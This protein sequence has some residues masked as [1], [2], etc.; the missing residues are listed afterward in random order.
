M[1]VWQYIL[2][3]QKALKMLNVLAF[4]ASSAFIGETTTVNITKENCLSMDVVNKLK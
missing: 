1:R 3:N 2:G 4:N